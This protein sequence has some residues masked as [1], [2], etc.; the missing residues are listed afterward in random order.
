MAWDVL[1]AEPAV[2]REIAFVRGATPGR[3]GKEEG[4]EDMVV[5]S[6][7]RVVDFAL[8]RHRSAYSV[9]G[10]DLNRDIYFRHDSQHLH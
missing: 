3:N 9:P 10:S 1:G 8:H 7:A 2:G 4:F 6:V 5:G